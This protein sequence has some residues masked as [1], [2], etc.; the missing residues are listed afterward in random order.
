MAMDPFA[1]I[2]ACSLYPDEHLVRAMVEASSQ[3]NATFVADIA[4][5]VTY[6]R[7]SSPADAHLLVAELERQG[8]RPIVGLL[9]LPPSW[10]NRAG[11]SQAD[12]FDACTNL[13]IGTAVL[14]DHYQTCLRTHTAPA[15]SGTAGTGGTGGAPARS[16]RSA[17]P[18]A[19]RLCALRRLGAEIGFDGYAEAVLSFLP[20]QRVLYAPSGFAPGGGSPPTSHE[21][22][23][24]RCEEPVVAARPRRRAEPVIAGDAADLDD[25]PRVRRRRERGPALTPGGAPILD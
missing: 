5:L 15:S 14:A 16:Q 2:L 8:G 4:T 25:A 9:G 22:D 18:E 17:P 23:S 13:K 12:L 10:V 6:D 20:R 3:G 19:I 21:N 11:K 1:L 24:C 7:S